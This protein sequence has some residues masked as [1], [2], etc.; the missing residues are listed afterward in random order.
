M[1]CEENEKL[2]LEIE[3]AKYSLTISTQSFTTENEK[4]NEEIIDLKI[5]RTLSKVKGILNICQA[6]KEGF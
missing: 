2:K 6:T 4:F 5:V 1:F 3:K